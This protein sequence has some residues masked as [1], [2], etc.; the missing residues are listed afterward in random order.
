MSTVKMCLVGQRHVGKGQQADAAARETTRLEV[1]SA[2][3][4]GHAPCREFQV[5]LRVLLDDFCPNRPGLRET[6]DV[7]VLR[8]ECREGACM[9][10]KAG[11]IECADLYCGF[12]HRLG[13][14]APGWCRRRG[15]RSCLCALLSSA[16]ARG[17]ERTRMSGRSTSVG[18]RLACAAWWEWRTCSRHGICWEGW[19]LGGGRGYEGRWGRCGLRRQVGCGGR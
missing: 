18:T 16:N 4:K 5:A 9:A 6:E 8:A 17:S 10:T 7:E 15:L 2:I 12:R 19:A 11:H 3:G 13:T 1:L 14:R